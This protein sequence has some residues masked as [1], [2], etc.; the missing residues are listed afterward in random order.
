V[1]G[2][3]LYRAATGLG[4]PLIRLYL[5]RRRASGKED[6]ERFGERL[7]ISARPRPS[8]RLVWMHAASVGEAT[9][10]LPLI[11]RMR[12]LWPAHAILLTTGTVTSAQVMAD[13]LPEGAFHQFVPVD[14]MTYVRRF[15]GH[16]RPDLAV[17]AESEFW[18]NMVRETARQGIPMVLVQGRISPRSYAGWRRHHRVIRRLLAGFTVCLGQTEADAE[19]LRALGA[20]G[21]ECRGNL[22]YAAPPLPAGADA[23][24][25]LEQ[26]FQTR[27]RWLA[28]STHPG[29]EEIAGEVHRR[30]RDRRRDLLTIIV[31][32][33]PERGPAI[34]TILGGSGLTVARRAA[35][36][37][38]T[39]ETE[40]YIADTI[41]ELGLFYRLAPI[42]FIGKS[43][44]AE[45][46][47]NPLE[48]AQLGCAIVH[49]PH[50]E[51]FAQIAKSL[52][53]AGASVGVTTAE[54]LSAVVLRL[55]ADDTER[56]RRAA[57]ARAVA[58]AE[59]GVLDAV[60]DV[61]AP[62]MDS[63]S[64]GGRRADA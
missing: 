39:P 52:D 13:R 2:L 36:E 51:N 59:A 12:Q 54:E 28:A 63:V 58:V 9:S 57:A 29:E 11:D 53:A 43:L 3:A 21:A 15:L 17:W 44:A 16:W 24:I 6:Q 8:G 25:E 45:G 38:V 49:G 4:G 7:G 55:L 1:I 14:R 47:Q 27:P 40:V 20:A 10:L 62:F 5:A 60:V 41:G 19:R 35:G 32:R 42:A 18:P 56:L 33:H 31:P 30:L 46:G 61:V 37:P 22:K 48:A 50:M 26:A 34:A 64:R 23:I